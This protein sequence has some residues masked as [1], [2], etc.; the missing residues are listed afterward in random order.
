LRPMGEE[1]SREEKRILKAVR[2]GSSL[3]EAV[4]EVS[5]VFGLPSWKAAW[6]IYCLWKKG[7]IDIAR[8]EPARSFA[9]YLAS[10]DALQLHVVTLLIAATLALVF[11]VTEPPA[12]YARYLLGGAFVLYLPGYA[13]IEAL[14]PRGDE[15]EPLE[16][17][18]LSIGLSLALVPLVGLVLNYTPWGIRLTPVAVSLALL[19]EALMA[20]ASYRKYR[21][22]RLAASK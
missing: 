20:V 21:L 9:G 18:A 5:R 7:Y 14:Y 2:S 10:P 13:L 22:A 16:R 1:L 4:G 12:V 15:L 3:E 11:T 6:K 17:L 8:R 19:T